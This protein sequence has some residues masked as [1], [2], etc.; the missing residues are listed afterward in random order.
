MHLHSHLHLSF[1]VCMHLQ[2]MSSVV[3]VFEPVV[4]SSTSGDVQ[5][6]HFQLVQCII[7][8]PQVPNQMPDALIAT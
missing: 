3:V 4:G 2:S 6:S 7:G 5:H 8:Q 1:Y